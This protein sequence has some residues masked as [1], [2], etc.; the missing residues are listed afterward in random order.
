MLFLVSLLRVPDL[1]FNLGEDS[2][3]DFYVV[4]S[5]AEVQQQAAQLDERGAPAFGLEVSNLI[6][7]PRRAVKDVVNGLHISRIGMMNCGREWLGGD[8]AG[9]RQLVATDSHRLAQIHGRTSLVSGNFHQ[10]VA[11]TH[12]LVGEAGLLRTEEQCNPGPPARLGEPLLWMVKRN[13]LSV[14]VSA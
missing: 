11:K 8:G 12:L 9:A 5:Q 13:Q 10:P 2:A 14:Y 3:Q 7:H 6:E 1:P 4:I